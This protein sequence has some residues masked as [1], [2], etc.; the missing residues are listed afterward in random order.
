MTSY[1][2]DRP[3]ATLSANPPMGSRADR[4]RE[5]ERRAE[6]VAGDDG[7]LALG[8]QLLGLG[9]PNAE[10]A[11]CRKRDADSRVRRTGGVHPCLANLV[12]DQRRQRCAILALGAREKAVHIAAEAEVA[13]LLAVQRRLRQRL[14]SSRARSRLPAHLPRVAAAG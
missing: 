12:F 3:R 14:R 13:E 8:Q 10:Q 4:L 7:D 9:E 6:R 2:G 5:L 1:N 11:R